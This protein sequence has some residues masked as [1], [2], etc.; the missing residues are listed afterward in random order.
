MYDWVTHTHSHLGG[1]CPHGCSY[2]YVQAMAVKFDTMK[3]RYGGPICLIESE[4]DVK[5]G[6]GKTIFI[7]HMNDLFAD[8]VPAD[9]VVRILQHCA[10]FPKNTYVFQTKNPGRLVNVFIDRIPQGSIVGTTIETNRYYPEIMNDCPLVVC[11]QIGMLQIKQR[12]P[13]LKRFVTVEPIL[14]LDPK[15]LA[16][17]IAEIAPD[18][19]NIGADSKKRGLPEPSAETIQAFLAALAARGVTI[20]KKNNLGR[21]M[22]P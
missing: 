1:K 16:D 19:L 4:L 20:R 3:A 21:L 18:F 6:E 17:G 11:R 15:E 5:Y 10:K 7:E 8:A 14:D 9:F 12:R 22:N 13:D 2:C